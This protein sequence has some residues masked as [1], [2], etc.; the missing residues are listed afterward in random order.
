MDHEV[1]AACGFDGADYD[2][3]ALMSA[4]RSLGSSWRE[5]IAVSGDQLRTRPGPEVW[6]A[7]EY[8]AHSRDVTALHAFGVEQALTTHEPTFPAIEGED[9]IRSAATSYS[10]ADPE[11]VVTEL[12]GQ[13]ARLAGLADGAGTRSWSRGLTIGTTR[14][15]VRRLLEHALHDSVHHLADVERG[16]TA[17]R[18]AQVGP[19]RSGDTPS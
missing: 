12:E 14:M 10:D 15:D 18:A 4:L 2:E 7:I 5:L 1:C 3:V 6:S 11:A 17:I 9:L 19:P 13:A 8:A 16:L